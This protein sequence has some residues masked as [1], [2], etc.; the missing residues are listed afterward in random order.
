MKESS[1]LATLSR[2]LGLSLPQT[3]VVIGVDRESGIDNAILAKLEIPARDWPQVLAS[4]PFKESELNPDSK[5][6]LPRDHGWWNP[7]SVPGLRAGQVER[8]NGRVL[9]IGVDASTKPDTIV[10]YLMSHT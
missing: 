10:L 6:Y 9:N 8:P 5:A 4:A 2:E 1:D 3:T 7:R